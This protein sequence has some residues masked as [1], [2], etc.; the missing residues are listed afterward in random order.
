[1]QQIVSMTFKNNRLKRHQSKYTELQY[2][3]TIQSFKCAYWSRTA[4]GCDGSRKRM[5]VLSVYGE[6]QPCSRGVDWTCEG[7]DL[8]PCSAT[9]YK[10]KL[11]QS[12]VKYHWLQW[13]KLE[14]LALEK[15]CRVLSMN[16]HMHCL[17][18]TY[19]Y[20]FRGLSFPPFK[21]P[22]KP[23]LNLLLRHF[24]SFFQGCLSAGKE[25]LRGRM[26]SK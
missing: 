9:D 19:L 2:V 18:F 7:K 5:S 26:F 11:R 23:H 22:L 13:P 21:V 4:L 20:L 15:E 8:F 6:R 25:V 1:M 24:S 16:R 10:C 12:I 3:P 14:G 17:Y